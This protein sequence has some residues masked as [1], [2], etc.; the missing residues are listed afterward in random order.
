MGGRLNLSTRSNC[1]HTALAVG[2]PM[3][4]LDLPVLHQLVVWWN[5]RETMQEHINADS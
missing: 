4:N 5:H 3:H 2:M 1:I